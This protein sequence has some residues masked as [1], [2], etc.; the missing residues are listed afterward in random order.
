MSHSSSMY[1]MYVKYVQ[2]LCTAPKDPHSSRI[3][4]V[5][6]LF[7]RALKNLLLIQYIE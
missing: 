5:Y 6:Y 2:H 7:L 1:N 4:R 3:E